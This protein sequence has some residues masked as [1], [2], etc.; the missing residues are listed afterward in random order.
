MKVTGCIVTYNNI[1]TIEKCI[2]TI[3]TFSKKNFLMLYVI[4]N[5]STD[6]TVELIRKQYP[7]IH[8]IQNKENRGFGGAHNQIIPYLTEE[9]YHF[10]I[11]PDIYLKEDTVAVL[12][13]FLEKKGE[14]TAM[15]TPEIE[16]PD[17]SIQ[18]LPQKEPK[19]RYVIFSK[20]PGFHYL[21]REYTQEMMNYQAPVK[22]EFCTGC[23]FCI[24]AKLFL[25][26]GGF[27]E[28]YFMYFEDADLSKQVRK[29]YDIYYTPETSVIHEWKRENVKS[30]IGRRR[31]I[32]SMIKYFLKW[33]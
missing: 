22:I 1:D 8:L 9:G 15:V 4:D 23:F 32:K 29:K 3:L 25:Q 27:D 33:K 13:D 16:N 10:V 12:V 5:G 14:K 30:K 6:G 7:E 21:R 26:I 18:H 19:I 17:G 31:F 11:N 20:I 28:R 2:N 24:R